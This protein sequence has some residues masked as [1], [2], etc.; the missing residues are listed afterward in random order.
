MLQHDFLVAHS[1]AAA[2][3]RLNVDV[4]HDLALRG[5]NGRG[6]DYFPEKVFEPRWSR[7]ADHSEV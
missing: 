1:T 7:L 3:R 6:P 2:Q 4:E 5:S